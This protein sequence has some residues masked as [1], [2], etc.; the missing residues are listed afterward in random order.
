MNFDFTETLRQIPFLRLVIPLILG[1]LVKLNLHFQI[2]I[3][4]LSS[5]ILLFLLIL[6]IF[7]SFKK[8]FSNYKTRWLFGM[9]F[10]LLLFSTGIF[11]VDI[12]YSKVSKVSINQTDGYLLASVVEKPEIKDKSIKATLEIKAIGDKDQWIETS[13]K[14]LIYFQKDSASKSINFGDKILF[15]PDISEKRITGNPNEFNFEKYLTYHLISDQTYLK[16]TS[17]KKINEKETGLKLY[18]YEIRDKFLNIFKKYGI[19]GN[20]YSVLS[21]LTVGYTSE[22]DSKI[23]HSYSSSGATHIL[24]VSGLHVGIIFIVFNYLLMFMEK[25]K[26]GKLIKAIFLI[27]FL[28]FYALLTGLSPSVLRSAAML[29]FVIVGQS[30][31]RQT[32][33][34]NSITASAFVLIIINPFIITD[35]GFQL[36]YLALISIIYFQPIIYNWFYIKNKWLDK[37]W[38][39]ISVSI[40][41]QIV[42]TPISLF[43]FHQFPNYFLLTNIIVVPLSTVIIYLALI[44]LAFSSFDFIANYLG[45]ALKYSVRILNNTISSIEGLPHSV[46]EN[47]Y[48]SGFQMFLIY[49]FIIIITSYFLLKRNS[50][51]KLSFI[52]IILFLISIFYNNYNSLKQRKLIV[53]NISGTTAINF[54][55]GKDN[56]L[57]SNLSK[58]ENSSNLIFTTKSNWLE[59]GLTKEKIVDINSLNRNS[60]FSNN[61][62][63]DNKN[64]LIKDRYLGFYKHRLLIINKDFKLKKYT[65][66]LK[67]DFIFLTSNNPIK[68]SDLAECYEMK[69]II[70][71]SSNSM[72]NIKKWKTDC[73]KYNIACNVVS[74]NGAFIENL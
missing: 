63:V 4:V 7:S 18:A 36:S 14:V 50:M 52:T 22:L 23:K 55:D 38:V 72:N 43:Y 40:A 33:I 53:Y 28:W 71:D 12:N 39:L 27:L 45:I 13:G 2:P 62:T 59:L 30:L 70:I 64:L 19:S 3:I 11:L 1:I 21:A 66:K 9:F 47:I 15:K 31:K 48:I 67:V 73:Q 16:S 54:I 60:L 49:F 35:L 58:N 32:N 65:K 5:I 69:K 42:S 6:I 44:L 57:I 34:Y 74:E 17:W 25:I 46:S 51:L 26:Y 24:S 68:I 41:A 37:I 61:L 20:E 8:L 56:I 29:S 10:N